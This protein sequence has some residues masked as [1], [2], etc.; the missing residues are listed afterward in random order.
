[1]LDRSRIFRVLS[2]TKTRKT[3]CVHHLERHRKIEFDR[4]FSAPRSTP[5]RVRV[6][7]TLCTI[8]SEVFFN[9]ISEGW[10]QRRNYSSSNFHFVDFI[11]DIR[12]PGYVPPGEKIYIFYFY[13]YFYL[14]LLKLTWNFCYELT[15]LRTRY[16]KKIHESLGWKKIKTEII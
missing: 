14:F 2:D 16:I 7:F 3:A 9:I 12:V 6:S 4:F 5:V 1:M 8:F 13:S 10:C 11:W 15:N